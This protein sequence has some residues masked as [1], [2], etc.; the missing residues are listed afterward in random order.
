MVIIKNLMTGWDLGVKWRKLFGLYLTK[1]QLVIANLCSGARDEKIQQ[2]GAAVRQ[3]RNKEYK[4]ICTVYTF[5]Q[6]SSFQLNE[7]GR[8]NS[9]FQH[10]CFFLNRLWKIPI[11]VFKVE[12]KIF[13]EFFYLK[14]KFFC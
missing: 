5:W 3:G 12:T 9:L 4:N 6:K 13:Q 7:K 11:L 14:F 1:T 2:G 8:E 10:Y